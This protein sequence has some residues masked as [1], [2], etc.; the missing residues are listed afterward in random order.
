M[1]S[2]PNVYQKEIFKFFS[3]PKSLNHIR[4]IKNKKYFL[5]CML[6][7]SLVCIFKFNFNH[8]GMLLNVWKE[9]FFYKDEELIAIFPS[10]MHFGECVLIYIWQKAITIIV[11]IR[12]YLFY[13]CILLKKIIHVSFLFWKLIWIFFTSKNLII[14]S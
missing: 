11:C 10:C 1:F 2:P 14:A 6:A 8:T 4:F 12:L 13:S 3:M 7:H 5:N 9:K